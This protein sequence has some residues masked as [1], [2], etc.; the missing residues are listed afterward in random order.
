MLNREF[1]VKHFTR[2]VKEY[3]QYA[4]NIAGQDDADDLFQECTLMLLEFSEERLISYWNHNEGLKPFFIRMLCLQYKSKTSKFHKEYRKQAQFIQRDGQ[5]IVLNG[6]QLEQEPD[7][8]PAE[9]QKLR[10]NIH[11]LNGEMFPCELEEMAFN[12]YV[13]TGSLRKALAALPGE[14]TNKF[15]LKRM[16]ELVRKYRRTI[17]KHYDKVA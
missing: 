12:L 13:E 17:K 8:N 3:Q 16:Q 5:K 7:I 9:I 4:K 11:T 15:D 2:N 6:Q 10:E 1:I 14:H